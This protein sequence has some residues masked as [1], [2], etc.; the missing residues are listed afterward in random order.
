MNPDK[1]KHPPLM[2]RKDG[3]QRRVGFELEFSSI[4]VEKTAKAIQSVFG[5]KL[6]PRN[7]VEHVVKTDDIGSFIV[8]LD[9]HYL[10][11]K[12]NES[13]QADDDP[14]WLESVSKLSAQ[15]VPVEVVCP[16]IKMSHLD[17]LTPMVEALRDE[18]AVGTEESLISA[19]GV[20]INAEIPLLDESTIFSYLK[21]F[22]L[23][24]WWLLEAHQVDLARKVSPYIDLYPES[25]LR[26]LASKSEPTMD[27]IFDDYLEHNATRN[28]ALD[29]LPMLAE[30]NS[31][32]V[33]EAIDDPKIK[34]RPTFHY[35]LPNCHI[36]RADW[37]LARAWNT[38][39]VVERL[40]E[41]TQDLDKLSEKFL[42]ASRPVLGVNQ[43]DWIEYINQ[44]LNDHELV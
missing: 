23:L 36:E 19:Y 4:T 8:E 10:K 13:D 44:W 39:C 31:D 42:A 1:F 16:P 35:R 20:H 33:K 15:L 28:R 17:L 22:A 24:Q 41:R 3:E 40:A 34:K 43:N 27:E 5:G 9:W 30:I 7:P 2:N 32:R 6:V 25:Y 18:G 21:A 37:S 11:Q 29:L 38:W 14:K 12:A 26:L